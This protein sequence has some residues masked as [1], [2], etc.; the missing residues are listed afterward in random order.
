MYADEWRVRTNST[1]THRNFHIPGLFSARKTYVLTAK[2]FKLLGTNLRKCW[3]SEDTCSNVCV[4]MLVLLTY[5]RVN[6][7]V[8]VLRRRYRHC[9][10]A[11]SFL[12]ISDTSSVGRQVLGVTH[13]P[14]NRPDQARGRSIGHVPHPTRS[15]GTRQEHSRDSDAQS[16][17]TE[18]LRARCGRDRRQLWP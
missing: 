16:R 7:I 11:F 3:F 14:R 9:L 10:P 2:H 17:A 5:G 18:F 13:R 8:V 12:P 4:W 15:A 1:K 6:G